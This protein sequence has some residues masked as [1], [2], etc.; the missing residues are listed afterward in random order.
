VFSVNDTTYNV[1]YVAGLFVGALV[2][3]ADGH[4]LPAVVVIGAGYAVVGL[5]YLT[6]SALF[7]R[8]PAPTGTAS[9]HS[10]ES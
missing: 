4:S 9:V 8:R 2:L 5:G 3:P 7:T 10:G 6:L 1:C